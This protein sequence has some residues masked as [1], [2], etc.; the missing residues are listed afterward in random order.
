MLDKFRAALLF[1][2]GALAVDENCCTVYEEE[3]FAGNNVT[4]CWDNQCMF[5]QFNIDDYGLKA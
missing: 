5:S 1:A 4:L 3:F 2:V